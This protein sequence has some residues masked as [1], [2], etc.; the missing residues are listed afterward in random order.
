MLNLMGRQDDVFLR[1]AFMAPP[2]RIPH[3]DAITDGET[4]DIMAKRIDDAS[5]VLAGNMRLAE[6]L[7]LSGATA[8]CINVCRVDPS[9]LDI[10]PN[11]SWADIRE[12]TVDE[13]KD[14]SVARFEVDDCIHAEVFVSRIGA[15][16]T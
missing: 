7:Y 11:V 15:A 8:A 12:R 5:A 6:V 9:D 10:D 14:I 2:G 4:L 16:C 3:P 1:G 13:L